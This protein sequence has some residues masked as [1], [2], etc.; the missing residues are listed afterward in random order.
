MMPSDHGLKEILSMYPNWEKYILFLGVTIEHVQHFKKEELGGLLALQH[1]RDGHCD[2]YG[3][4]WKILLGVIKDQAPT[5]FPRVEQKVAEN[6]NWT[7]G[8]FRNVS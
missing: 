8:P 7:I 6:K 5:R 3:S 1:W 2:G 4:T